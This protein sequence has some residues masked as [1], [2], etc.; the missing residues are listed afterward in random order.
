MSSSRFGQFVPFWLFLA[1]FD[2][3][4]SLEYKT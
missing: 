1:P 3:W 4:C 2:S